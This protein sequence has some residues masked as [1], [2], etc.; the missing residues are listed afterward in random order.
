MLKL[1]KKEVESITLFTDHGEIVIRFGKIRGN[2]VRI[3][4]D[5]L[6]DVDVVRMELLKTA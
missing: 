3:A 6:D 1:S 5:A 2:Q 4:V